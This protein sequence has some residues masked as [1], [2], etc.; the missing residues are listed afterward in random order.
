MSRAVFCER[1]TMHALATRPGW[2]DGHRLR[3][4]LPVGPGERGVANV[5][6]EAGARTD[7]V[8]YLLAPEEF[9]RLDRTE[10][11]HLGLY[12]RVAVTV[13]VGDGEHLPAFTYRSSLSKPERKPSAR[14]M[15]LLLE[16]AAEHGLP[17][18]YVRFL[19]SFELAHDE[20][21][22]PVASATPGDR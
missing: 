15:R 8:L 1:R 13:A 22:D 7:G 14:Y 12:R 16:G 19:E 21:L 10:G 18:E 5:E 17:L 20:R 9:D 11:V 3:F 4:D 2:L 6:P